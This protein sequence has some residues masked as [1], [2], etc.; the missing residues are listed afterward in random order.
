[1]KS[2]KEI[3]NTLIR[4]FYSEKINGNDTVLGIV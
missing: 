4:L 3:I 1:M 2:K